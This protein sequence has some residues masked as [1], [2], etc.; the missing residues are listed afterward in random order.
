MALLF[1]KLSVELDSQRRKVCLE[2]DHPRYSHRKSHK[3]HKGKVKLACT[4]QSV[5]DFDTMYIVV[6]LHHP[7]QCSR[8]PLLSK[9]L[10]LVI[11]KCQTKAFRF[12]LMS[13]KICGCR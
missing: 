12:V 7:R 3:V 10:H 1:F 13:R 4:K 8:K 5:C 11:R 2:G 6:Q 9:A